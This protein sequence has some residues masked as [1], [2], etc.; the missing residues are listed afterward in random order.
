MFAIHS[1]VILATAAPAVLALC[2]WAALARGFRA[3]H[4]TTLR[5]P[6]W[7][8]AGSLAAVAIGEI[9]ITASGAESTPGAAQ[10]RLAA[11]A[12]TFCPLVALLGAKRPQDRAWQLIVLSFWVILALPSAQAWLM[13]PGE[14]PVMHPLWVGFVMVLAIV[15]CTNY[16]P[17]RFW[18]AGLLAA[19][20]Q[21]VLH[22]GQL[23]LVPQNWAAGA[24]LCGL[25]LLAAALVT[26][27]VAARRQLPAHEPLDRLWIDFRDRYGVVWGLRVAE[28]MNATAKLH[29]WGVI[30]GWNGF[31]VVE[32]D[33]PAAINSELENSLRTI[34]RRFV[35]AEWI[36]RR[37]REH[38]RPDRSAGE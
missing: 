5:A 11:A 24:P 22:W 12:T 38:P 4:G 36:D 14:P 2:G 3:S 7:W 15:G 37:L 10:L 16:L 30:L 33:S 32:N 6:W 8:A 18:L 35:S 27:A 19:V 25:G 9:V 23:P 31:T 21:L 13:T 26:A 29:D 28:R 1:T 20:G 34:L 17:T